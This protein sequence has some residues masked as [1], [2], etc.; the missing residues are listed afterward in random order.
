MLGLTRSEA[1]G[2]ARHA[3]VVRRSEQEAVAFAIDRV[4]GQQEAVVRPL[5][6]PLV[7]VNGV[8]GST[9]LGDGQ[10]TLVLD[11]VALL[12]APRETGAAR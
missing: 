2:A 12:D 6:D 1:T 5:S 10:P 7:A 11:L 4:L 3:V 9:D 8:S